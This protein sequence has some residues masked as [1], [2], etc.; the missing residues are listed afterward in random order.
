MGVLE[1]LQ[2]MA[3]DLLNRF[4]GDLLGRR[5]I[6][7]VEA[8]PLYDRDVGAASKFTDDG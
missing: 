7:V 6:V 4:A 1:H 3:A 2:F 5:N 8:C